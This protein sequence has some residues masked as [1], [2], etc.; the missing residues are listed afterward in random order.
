MIIIALTICLSKMLSFISLQDS[1][2]SDETVGVV[3]IV[4]KCAH[5]ASK[6]SKQAPVW[7]AYSMF[8]FCNVCHGHPGQLFPCFYTCLKLFLLS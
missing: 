4:S 3:L 5:S 8:P 6:N 7:H 1:F 2:T